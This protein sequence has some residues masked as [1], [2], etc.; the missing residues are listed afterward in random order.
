MENAMEVLS[1][2]A[3]FYIESK[4]LQKGICIVREM[5]KIETDFYAAYKIAWAISSNR[6]VNKVGNLDQIHASESICYVPSHHSFIRDH[7]MC[8][9]YK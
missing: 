4:L 9:F 1:K 2:C 5:E 6:A 3:S 7:M 8:S